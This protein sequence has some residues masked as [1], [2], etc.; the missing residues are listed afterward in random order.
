[1]GFIH[2]AHI[3]CIN[4]FKMKTIKKDIAIVLAILL[5][6]ILLSS[7]VQLLVTA[8]SPRTSYTI[9]LDAGHGARDGGC[10]GVSGSLE[11]DLNLEYTLEIKR[12]LVDAGVNVVLTR[13]KDTALYSVFAKNKKMDDMRKRIAI[14]NR[15]KPDLYMSIHMNS[16]TYTYRQ[17][18]Q[19][20]YGQVNQSGKDFAD[21]LASTYNKLLPSASPNSTKGDLYIL[22]KSEYTGVLIECGFLSNAEEESMLL[23]KEYRQRFA[24]ATFC[25]VML[26][27]GL[28]VV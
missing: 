3:L 4:I 28:Q 7:S 21:L 1:M 26:Y 17:G 5:V 9:L 20:Y 11:K 25:A 23:T 24:Y 10:V 2:Y 18:A 14:I 12:M 6:T 16:T 22:D 8:T 13:S 27:L 15:T 19:V